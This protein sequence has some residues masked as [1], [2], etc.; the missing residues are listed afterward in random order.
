MSIALNVLANPDP[1]V[2]KKAPVGAET[3]TYKTLL[4]GPF[5][6]KLPTYKDVS[7]AQF[8]DHNWQ[9]KN[10]I[11]SVPKLLKTVEGLVSPAF[12]EDA[13]QGFKHA[14]M[15]VRVSPYLLSLIDWSDPYNDPLRIQFIPVGSRLLPDHPK[16]NLDSLHEQEDAPVPGLTHRYVDKALF[17]PLA[18][19]P[20][21]CRFCT[22]SYAV[23]IDTEEVEKVS[24]KVNEERWKR[25]YAYIASR[26]ELEDI[27]ISGG[28]AYNLRASQITEIGEALL[29]M[30]NIRRMRFATKGP[31]VMP[32]KLLTDDAWTD[33]L[34]AI[35]EKGR[36]LHKEVVLHTHF[37]HP[38]EITAI[39]ERA[40]NKLFER[41]IT[42][43]NQSVLQRRVNDTPEIMTM[44][45]KRLGHV[46]VHPYYVYVH[47]LVKGVEDL[48]TTLDTALLVEKHVRGTTA[49]FNTPT[50]VVDAPGGGGKRNAH[51]YEYYD[52]DT[53][54]SVYTAP[55][56][57]P[58]EYFVYYDPLDQLSET[59]R[60]R[61]ADPA[62]QEI[63]VNAALARAKEH[64]R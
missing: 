9:S 16:L 20:V 50:F 25:A 3:L 57:K 30:P 29:A 64:A 19:C 56:V 44:L 40:M 39:T 28:D 6:Q 8:L 58:G 22:R 23:G 48:R 41:G 38:R 47:D 12:I 34:T 55:S 10:S 60:R 7:E 53:G 26:P 27:V 24:I 49:G 15:S 2:A 32:Q 63:M 61:W 13:E 43:R 45:V 62:D 54:I 1:I 33:A 52:R 14:P 59:M 17:L 5:W 46:N 37:N 36:K 11:T 21:Y 31:A 4:D 18:T 35:V 51:S 42:V